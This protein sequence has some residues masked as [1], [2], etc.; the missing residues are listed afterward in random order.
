[1]VGGMRRI[2][3][4]VVLRMIVLC[5]VGVGTVMSVGLA[6]L[7]RDPGGLSPGQ[8]RFIVVGVPVLAVLLALVMTVVLLRPQVYLRDMDEMR[9]GRAW[10]LAIRRT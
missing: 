1:M 6:F 9:A 4:I 3:E 8:V 2:F 5:V 7:L 10:T